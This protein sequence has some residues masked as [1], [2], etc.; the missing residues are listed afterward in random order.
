MKD[1]N[2]KKQDLVSSRESMSTKGIGTT[3]D[4]TTIQISCIS[5]NS[6]QNVPSSNN[7]QQDIQTKNFQKEQ[8]FQGGV[9][10]VLRRWEETMLQKMGAT[11]VA[12]GS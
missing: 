5:I 9:R 8:N 6:N 7:N 1:I 10:N 12:L 11:K 4:A 3:V 2:A